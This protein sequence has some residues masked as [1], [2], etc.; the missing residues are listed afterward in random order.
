M[1]R[2]VE[3]TT[4]VLHNLSEGISFDLLNV[5]LHLRFVQ[6]NFR[7]RFRVFE[8]DPLVCFSTDLCSMKSSEK[9]RDSILNSRFLS[10]VRG[11]GDF[12]HLRAAPTLIPWTSML[13][14]SPVIQRMIMLLLSIQKE[15]GECQTSQ[16]F[17]GQ[18]SRAVIDWL[19]GL[20]LYG[21]SL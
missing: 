1:M 6:I 10:R 20:W 19:Y 21:Q 14:N 17:Q 13:S 16:L 11:G 3:T 15:I 5:N 7:G 4:T 12:S 18:S 2:I 9:V 8:S